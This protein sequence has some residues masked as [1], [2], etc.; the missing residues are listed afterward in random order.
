VDGQCK[1]LYLQR[2]CG[3]RRLLEG[4]SDA[5]KLPCRMEIIPAL[6]RPFEPSRRLYEQHSGNVF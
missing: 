1:F 4:V 2:K 6:S 5:S 3:R